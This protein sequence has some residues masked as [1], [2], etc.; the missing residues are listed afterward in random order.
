MSEVTPNP[1]NLNRRRSRRKFFYAL[2]WF[3]LGLALGLVGSHFLPEKS[4]SAAD[5]QGTQEQIAQS[6]KSLHNKLDQL[7]SLGT[8][9]DS[10]TTNVSNLERTISLTQDF[11]ALAETSTLDTSVL[12]TASAAIDP[13]VE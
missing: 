1:P 8:S 9:V 2:T 4:T 5:L 6:L 7:E 11:A 3:S 12:G 13:L 10:L